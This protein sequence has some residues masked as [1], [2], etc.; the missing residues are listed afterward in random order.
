MLEIVQRIV[1]LYKSVAVPKDGIDRIYADMVEETKLHLAL[2]P[3]HLLATDY[4]G[5]LREIRTLLA[6]ITESSE[7][8]ILRKAAAALVA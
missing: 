1:L 4:D 8:L 3:F 6:G 2:F 5:P 7:A